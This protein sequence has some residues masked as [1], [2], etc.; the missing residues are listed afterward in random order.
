[1]IFSIFFKFDESIFGRIDVNPSIWSV[2]TSVR[3]K[4]HAAVGGR[5]GYPL[6]SW[7][8]QTLGLDPPLNMYRSN[9]VRNFCRGNFRRGN[10][11]RGNF[12]RREFSPP[13]I[14]AAGNFRRGNFRRREFSPLGIFAAGN[15]R[16]GNFRR[17][18]F[19][20]PG[21]FAAGNFCRGNFRRREFSPW[22]FS[23]PG[24]LT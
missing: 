9:G 15:F 4:L 7:P 14:F 11:R 22:E 16:R 19:S 20:P 5:V 12:R 2:R 21:I 6:S 1:M 23:P 13:G 8:P 24:I 18:D 3:L 10:F 17:R